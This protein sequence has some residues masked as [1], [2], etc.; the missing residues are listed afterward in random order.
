MSQDTDHFLSGQEETV[1]FSSTQKTI[2]V[3]KPVLREDNGMMVL[4]ADVSGAVSGTCFFST[5]LA[6]RD[7][8]DSASSNCFL[9]GLLFTAMYAGCDLVMEGTVSEKLLFHTRHFLIPMLVGFFEGQLHP[10]KILATQV[11]SN[12]NLKANAVGTGFSGG[13]D[14]FYTIRQFSLDYN[15]PAADRINTLLFFNAGSHGMGRDKKRLEWLEKKFQERRNALSGYSQDL[16]LPFIVVDSNIFAFMQKGHLQNSSLTSCAAALFLGAKL[17]LYYFG[18]AG[19][20]YHDLFYPGRFMDRDYDIEKIDDFILPHICTESFTA[21]SDGS[22]CSRTQKTMMIC[23]DP[24][25][26]KYLN[27]CNNPQA[28]AKNCSVCYKCLRTL[29][30]LD[31]LGVTGQFGNVFDLAKYTA[32]ERSRYI[33]TV[34]NNRKRDPFL[35][36]IC[37]FAKSRNFDLKSKTSVLTRIYMRFTETELYRFLRSFLKK[38]PN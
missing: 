13:I 2:T 22:V 9:I 18:S 29:L 32:R 35:Q 20:L 27:V 25:V 11:S 15:G 16:G 17:R 12:C 4:S 21:S 8:V 31:I 28:V 3:S 19:F 14:S 24:L 33:A 30:T 36:D 10:V 1:V 38:R 6:N 23:S 26:Q 34:L 5:E 7:Y 37:D